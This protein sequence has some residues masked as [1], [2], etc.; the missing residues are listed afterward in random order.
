MKTGLSEVAKA[1]GLAGR[2]TVLQNDPIVICDTGHNIAGI[3]YNMEQLK[4]LREKRKDSKLRMVIGFVADKAIADILTL[5]PRDAEYYITNARIPRALP[6][7]ELKVKFTEAGLPGQVY[8]DVKS[9]YEAALNDSGQS[10][11]VFVGGS[12]FI[13]ADLLAQ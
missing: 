1:T 10:D 4:K 2:W 13:V 12:T 8:P 11:I 5:L 3:S 7:E 9:A 6:A